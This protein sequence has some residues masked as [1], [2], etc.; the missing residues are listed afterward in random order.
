MEDDWNVVENYIKKSSVFKKNAEFTLSPSFVPKKLPKREREIK[1]L[2]LD[3]QSLTLKN[4]VYS[5][6]VAIVGTPGTGKTALARFF[7]EQLCSFAKKKGIKLI[8]EYIDCFAARTKSS[9]LSNLLAKFN[10]TSR[11]FSDDE[12]LSILI[13]RLDK[14]E[15]HLLLVIDEAYVLGGEA[16]LSLMRSG[17]VYGYGIPRISTIIISRLTEWRTI[18]NTTLTGRI[19]DQI[20]LPGYSKEDLLEIIK[21]RSALAFNAGAISDDILE[22]VADIASK[23][24]NARHAIELLFRAGKMADHLSE[25]NITPEMIRKAKDEVFPEFRPE[26]FYDLKKHELLSALA[27]SK[28]LKHK[29]IVSTTVDEAYDYYR[30]ACEEY[31]TGPKSKSAFRS[32]IKFLTDLG[33]IASVVINLSKGKRG[34]RAQLR[35]YDLPAE[36]LEERC[37]L[38]LSRR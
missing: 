8:F 31:D 5:V 14:D 28:R 21:Y 18:L 33:L 27:I 20:N 37:R 1:R 19:I 7:G 35:L 11:G 23:T 2:I 32:Y 4:G 16:I 12:L 6:N 38:L 24:E 26:I 22:M 17:E 25:D 10:I 30:V 34:R 36:V 13:K 3:F 15:A 29:G 9:I